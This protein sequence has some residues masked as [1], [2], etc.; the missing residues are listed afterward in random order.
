MCAEDDT[1]EALAV[2]GDRIAAVGGSAEIES[3]I[4]VRTR[5]VD[6][7]GRVVIPGLT[8]CHVHVAGQA[9]MSHHVDVRDFFGEVP[10]L[11]AVFGLMAERA[12]ITS[13]GQWVTAHGGPLQDSRMVEGRRPTREE[14]DRA[15]PAHPAFVFFGGHV[16]VANTRA[17][18]A[19]GVTRDSVAPPRGVIDFDD[20]GEPTGVLR[21]TAQ[22]LVKNLA[23]EVGS[24]DDAIA[25]EL[26]RAAARGVTSVHEI[27]NGPDEVA[28]FQRL[29]AAGRLACRVQM[30]I[31]VIES[32]FHP[33][34]L[35]ALGARTG[36]GSNLLRIGGIKMSV[37]GGFTGRNSAFYEALEGDDPGHP[38][39]RIESDELTEA[40]RTHHEAGIRACVHAMGDQ[41]IDMVL[42]A[43]EEV[44]GTSPASGLRHRVEHLGN[45]QLDGSR[46][47]RLGSLG[48]TPVPNPV[49]LHYL[50]EVTVDALGKRRAKDAWPFR[51]ILDAGLPLAFGTDAP[52]YWPIDPLRD[53]ATAV[54]RTSRRG[55][56]I[57]PGQAVTPFQAL[58]AATTTAAWLG[59]V[60]DRLGMIAPGKLADIAVLEEDPL[61]VPPNRLGDIEVDLTVM[62]G[63]VTYTRT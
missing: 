9:A 23:P 61:N 20:R 31:R 30:L 54:S 24:L 51:S 59:E 14:L 7:A 37:D 46:L 40:I 18:N 56:E 26:E 58:Q 49:F 35:L 43:F 36:F 15:V 25:G 32:R 29:E 12:A 11:A 45:W 10:D 8:D 57:E 48:L 63:R 21:E 52:A 50:G 1:A 33:E 60:E 42:D 39:I 55:T 17:L 34:V 4:G 3:L 41:A 22:R 28:A 27:T 13:K 6:L 47:A 62:D 2:R 5:V 38:M 53:L 44:L 16:T 19:A